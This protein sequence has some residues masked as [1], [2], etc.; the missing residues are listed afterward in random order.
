MRKW[1]F[2]KIE[3]LYY[4]SNCKRVWRSLYSNC[5]SVKVV[6]MWLFGLKYAHITANLTSCKISEL[7]NDVVCSLTFYRRIS[8]WISSQSGCDYV[9]VDQGISYHSQLW[10]ADSMSTRPSRQMTFERDAYFYIYHFCI[11]YKLRHSN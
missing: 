4:V 1:T 7:Y 5:A 2:F 11:V 8:A 3:L 10:W 9:E 6:E